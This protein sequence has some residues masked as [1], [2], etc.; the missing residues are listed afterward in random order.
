M[1]RETEMNSEET[2]YLLVYIRQNC[3]E[4]YQQTKTDIPKFW[5]NRKLAK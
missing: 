2:A 3:F 1:F 4:E 5:I